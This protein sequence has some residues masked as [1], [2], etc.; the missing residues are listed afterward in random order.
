MGYALAPP[1]L[2]S[3]SI[4]DPW[5]GWSIAQPIGIDC[6]LKYLITGLANLFLRLQ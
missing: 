2:H 4:I 6:I 1:I 3:E 5:A